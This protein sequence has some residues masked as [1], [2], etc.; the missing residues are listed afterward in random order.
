LLSLQL[1]LEIQFFFSLI[2]FTE[3]LRTTFGSL[4]FYFLFCS[5]FTVLINYFL[6]LVSYISVFAIVLYDIDYYLWFVVLFFRGWKI[7]SLLWATHSLRF[8]GVAFFV[9][10]YLFLVFLFWP[11]YFHVLQLLI[12][13]PVFSHTF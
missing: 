6:F 9:P 7:C 4:Y 8:L 2:G 11:T 5:H 1:G 3:C 10:F 12:K 13:F